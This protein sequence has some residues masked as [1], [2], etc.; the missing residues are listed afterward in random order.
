[1]STSVLGETVKV[2]SELLVVK[3]SLLNANVSVFRAPVIGLQEFFTVLRIW[4]SLLGRS[5][6]S[7][8]LVENFILTE[9]DESLLPSSLVV[10]I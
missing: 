6:T 7:K 10:M 5:D 8:P 9:L 3:N 2:D 4:N 1:M